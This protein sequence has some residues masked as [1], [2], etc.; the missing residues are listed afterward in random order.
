VRRV[1]LMG[2]MTESLVI[3]AAEQGADAY[4]TGQLRVPALSAVEQTGI[5]VIAVGHRRG[6]LW[7][8]RALGHLLRERWAEL[9]VVIR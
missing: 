4:V 8:L 1:A 3:W 7:A 9:D 6:E 5:G 2:A